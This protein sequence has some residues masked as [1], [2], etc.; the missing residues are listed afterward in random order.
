MDR[1]LIIVLHYGDVH[2][3]ITCLASLLKIK[4]TAWDV[5]VINN[6]QGSAVERTICDSFPSIRYLEISENVGFARGNN[7]G[8]EIATR[9]GYSYSL[10]L[11]N[12]TVVDASFLEQLLHC[13]D[14]DT[15]IAL[16]GPMIFRKDDAE[17]IWAAGGSINLWKAR[18][19]PNTTKTLLDEVTIRDVDYLPG[20]CVLIR[21]SVL[22][23]IGYL[24][25]A[26]FLA[27][28]EAEFALVARKHGYRVV[29]CPR[30]MIWH[31]IGMSGQWPP[32][33]Q[34]NLMRNRFLFLKRN[35]FVPFNQLLVI[36]LFAC[37]LLARTYSRRLIVM[38]FFDHIR[39][40]SITLRDLERIEK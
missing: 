32:R 37:L 5:L 17:R 38:S 10:I 20:A 6:G 27:Y 18:L 13:M 14:Y 15:S 40:D 24:P 2:D 19:T 30:S 33:Y 31:K 35:I 16:A 25:E 7:K 21:N 22:D 9:E 4:G 29:I 23:K 8:L 12:D 1:T 39:Y 3:T 34:Y 11:N 28:E 26:Y 36:G